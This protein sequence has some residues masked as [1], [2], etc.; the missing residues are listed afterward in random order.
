MWGLPSCP[1]TGRAGGVRDAAGHAPACSPRA[2]WQGDDRGIHGQA[3]LL[4]VQARL[5]HLP[6]MWPWANYLTSRDSVSPSIKCQES[7]AFQPP[8]EL[9][10]TM[11]ASAALGSQPH[12]TDG[13][14]HCCSQEHP[15]PEGTHPRHARGVLSSGPRLESPEWTGA[16]T[17]ATNTS[18]AKGPHVNATWARVLGLP[19]NMSGSLSCLS[20]SPSPHPPCKP[21][22]WSPRLPCKPVPRPCSCQTISPSLQARAQV[23]LVPQL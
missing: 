17:A 3:R 22:P 12:D 4:W 1:T 10:E 2:W 7:A 20:S 6:A 18:K 23:P 19:G 9:G 8:W 16:E 21:V 5:C 11:E 14:Y 15:D 13:S